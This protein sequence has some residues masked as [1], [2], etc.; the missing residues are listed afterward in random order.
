MTASYKN[1]RLTYNIIG[2]MLMN[3]AVLASEMTPRSCKQ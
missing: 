3:D 2:T 1:D